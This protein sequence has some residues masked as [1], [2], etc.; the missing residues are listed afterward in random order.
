MAGLDLPAYEIRCGRTWATD[1]AATPALLDGQGEA[2]G[3]QAGP[4]LGIA[5]HGLFED[6]GA[7]RALFGSRVRTLDDSFDA[8]ADLIDDH[9]GAA[10]LRALFNA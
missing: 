4:V 3:W 9:L 8:L 2:I 1:G 7:L 5:A 6:A 10:T